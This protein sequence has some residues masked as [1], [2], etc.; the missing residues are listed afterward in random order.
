MP[1]DQDFRHRP[2]PNTQHDLTSLRIEHAAS[3]LRRAGALDVDAY[4][5]K[6]RQNA[7][8][9]VQVVNHLSEARVALM[10]LESGAQVTMRDSPDLEI[11]WLGAR[12]FAEVKHFNRKEQDGLDEAA[13]RAAKG[14]FVT[15]GDTSLI[16]GRHSYEQVSD[17]ARR[18]KHQYV[19]G[20]LNILAVDS[21]SESML[22]ADATAR[23]GAKEYDEEILK[24]PNDF[25]LR[26]LHG[27]M[28][29]AEWGSAGLGSRNVAFAMTEHALPRMSWDLIQ[30]LKSIGRG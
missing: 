7:P 30:A 29:V 15:F 27:I 1:T 19:E 10:F 6:L 9:A 24:N 22:L 25:A 26:R 13:A 18:K 2:G 8:N 28:L 11:G 23:S 17:V 16:E 20:A 14:G 3:A 21:G 5:L 12:F 4:E